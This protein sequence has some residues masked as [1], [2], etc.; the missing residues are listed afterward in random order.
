MKRVLLPVLQ[1]SVTVALLW[2]IFRDPAKN[3]DMVAA[4]KAANCY[5]LI[6]GV[7]SVGVAFLLQTQRWRLL[8]RVQGIDMGW[9]RALRV[10]FIGA[11]FNL[12]LPGGTGGDV[13]KI[14]YA[15]R[16]TVSKKSA[17]LLSV[18]VDRMMGLIALVFLSIILCSLRLQEILSHP[19]TQTLFGTLVVI[20]GGS[21]GL[22]VAG[23]MVDRF[24]LAH[25]LPQW[26]PLRA[27]IIDLSS[28][29]STYAR[30]P[31]TLLATFAISLPAHLLLFLA[32]FF[33][34]QAFA[35]FPGWDGV[36]DIFSVLPIINT[37]ASL[38]ISLS[39]VG[40]REKLFQNVFG[41]LFG[42]PQS[43]AVMISLVS[44]LYTV[45]W[46]LV[47]CV[48]YFAYRPSGGIHLKEVEEDVA[49]VE[50]SIEKQA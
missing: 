5:W 7:L 38:P 4:L 35:V 25:K 1:I 19:L 49:E 6:P 9:W 43:I 16:E 33:T 26:L 37:I 44:F 18:L 24:H 32:F 30:S 40:V 14:F 20:L 34:A 17:A 27:K 3:R 29:F 2:L 11:F 42:T 12:L 45:F 46:G 15:M 39:G 48:V 13:V 36:L 31:S 21:F 47:G 41:E 22:I 28:A 8:M 23:F 50:A 10:Y